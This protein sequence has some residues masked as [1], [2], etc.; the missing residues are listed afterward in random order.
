VVIPIDGATGD[1]GTGDVN[2][3]GHIDVAVGGVD[4]TGVGRIGVLFGVGDGRLGAPVWNAM[5]PGDLPTSMTVTDFDN[6]NDLDLITVGG[7]GAPEVFLN[8]ADG[9]FGMPKSLPD[10]SH[11]S[12]ARVI[13]AGD[14]D[15]DKA[16]DL[17][18]NAA[19]TVLA[20][21]Q[22]EGGFVPKELG[23]VANIATIGGLAIAD[24][25]GDGYGDVVVAGIGNGFPA[26]A[27]RH[28]KKDHADPPRVLARDTKE[29][30]KGKP[31]AVVTGDFDGDG[32]LDAAALFVD[33]TSGTLVTAMAKPASYD[34]AVRT[35]LDGVD[36]RSELVAGD[37]DGDGKTDLL[38]TTKDGVA[39][40]RATA[41]G[42]AAPVVL[43]EPTV[44]AVATADLRGEKMLS[45]ISVHTGTVEVWLPAC[46]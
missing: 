37:L 10:G 42:F 24:M 43:P 9:T 23:T 38:V 17:A 34:V 16:S 44:R 2:S 1:L 7:E 14:L 40:F 18:E 15:G 11:R 4:A 45:V 28:G 30:V 27:I 36:D 33:G 21:F 8:N 12:G 25:N 35:R 3:D 26:I 19:G 20:W 22:S 41:D 39:V 13:R 6:D 46:R 32:K 29:E 5:L 31:V